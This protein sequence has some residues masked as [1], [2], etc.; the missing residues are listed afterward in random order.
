MPKRVL[1]ALLIVVFCIAPVLSADTDLPWCADQDIF[2]YNSSSDISGYRV[3]SNVPEI[4]PQAQISTASFD[5]GDGEVILGTWATPVGHPGVT[6][7]G[8]G[9]WRFR[10]YAFASSSTGETTLEFYVI[11]R[12]ASGV[13]TNLFYGNAITRDIDRGTTPTE[14]LTSYTRR[15]YTTFF[16]GDRLVIRVNASTTSGTNRI[17]TMDVA[18]NTNA[19]MVSVSYFLCDSILAESSGGGEGSK[20]GGSPIGTDLVVVPF[21]VMPLLC[22][23]Y[24]FR[25]DGY[26][27]TNTVWADLIATGFGAVISAVVMI[28]FIIGGI[29]SVPVTVESSVF[30]VPSGM[31]VS[32]AISNASVLPSLGNLGSG[33]HVVS[34][35]SSAVTT[36]LGVSIHTYDSVIVQYQDFGVALLYGVFTVILVA[37]FA[38]TLYQSW[39]QILGERSAEDDPER[40]RS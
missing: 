1:A 30:S 26:G 4:A 38:W 22:T 3:M 8:P 9:L 12:S 33:M 18:G 23:F 40:W 15:N 2:F 17:V 25:W 24:V 21:L 19:S 35:I 27:G 28:W 36:D 34:S 5:S 6:T 31:S 39:N 13:E 37:L 20:A 14:Y 16:S 11:N 29:T 10:T 32:D 7:L